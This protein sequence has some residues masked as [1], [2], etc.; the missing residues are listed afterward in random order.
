MTESK[1]KTKRKVDLVSSH[2]D[3]EHD[4]GPL[5]AYTLEG[6]AVSELYNNDRIPAFMRYL[7]KDGEQLIEEEIYI[8]DLD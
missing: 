3:N 5:A 4:N 1:R 8:P 6:S 7:P 2:S